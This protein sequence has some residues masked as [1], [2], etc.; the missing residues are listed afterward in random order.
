MHTWLDLVREVRG[1]DSKIYLIGNKK[2]LKE[3]RVVSTEQIAE[4]ANR[5]GLKFYEMS[6]L[7]G[8]NV[9]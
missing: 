3:S 6:A 4:Y 8:E 7:D 2:D 5:E 1:N 9:A